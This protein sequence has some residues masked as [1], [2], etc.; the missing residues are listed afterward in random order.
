VPLLKLSTGIRL[1]TQHIQ[2][3]EYYPSVSVGSSAL[4]NGVMAGHVGASAT[5]EQNFLCIRTGFG[6]VRVRG[7]NAAQDATVLE[8]AGVQVYRS[9]LG[10]S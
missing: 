2:R 4:L 8:E 9:P 1:L 6:N 5:H 7:I 10:D 3:A